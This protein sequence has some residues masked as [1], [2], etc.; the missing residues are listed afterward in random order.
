MAEKLD[1]TICIHTGSGSRYL[2]QPFDVERNHTFAHNR[3]LPVVAFRDLVAN[4]IPEQFPKLRFGFIEA[5]ASWVP[6]IFHVL[7]RSVRSDLKNKNPQ[8][9]FRDYRFWVACEADEELPHLLNYIGEDHIVIGSDYGHNDPSKEPEFVKNLRAREDVSPH[10]VEKILCEN[11]RQLY[12]LTDR[13][14]SPKSYRRRGRDYC[15]SAAEAMIVMFYTL[16]L[17]ATCFRWF[18]LSYSSSNVLRCTPRNSTR[19]I[20]AIPLCPFR[21]AVLDRP[22]S[23]IVRKRRSQNTAALYQRRA[24]CHGGILAGECKSLSRGESVGFDLCPRK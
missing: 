8:D 13:K 2:M 14:I 23:Q 6:Y 18:A 21:R 1:L 17:R 9:L 11:A 5:A 4:R 19:S 15:H 10:V 16:L 22:R 7:R 12:G 20:S 24:A 3:V